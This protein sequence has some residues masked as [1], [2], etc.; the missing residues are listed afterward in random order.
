MKGKVSAYLQ[1]CNTK[2]KIKVREVLD[3][4]G[5]YFGKAFELLFN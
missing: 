3:F 4:F 1:E 2:K 5:K